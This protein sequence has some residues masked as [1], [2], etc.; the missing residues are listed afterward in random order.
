MMQVA[1]SALSLDTRPSSSPD[2]RAALQLHG[3]Q[4]FEV[5][6]EVLASS[7]SQC[8]WG[9]HYPCHGSHGVLLIC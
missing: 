9:Q 1:K 7:V 5:E 3:D 4:A 2:A 6:V 8:T